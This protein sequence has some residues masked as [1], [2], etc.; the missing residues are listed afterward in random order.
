MSCQKVVNV[1][2]LASA[3]VSLA[4]VIGG[5]TVYVQRE[6]I[7][8]SVTEKVLGA[9]GGGVPSL[10]ASGGALTGDV[11]SNPVPASERAM[12]TSSPF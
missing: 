11:G 12:G 5:A 10:P 6:A 3:A 8:K 1:L 4:V 2:A 9:L 7:I